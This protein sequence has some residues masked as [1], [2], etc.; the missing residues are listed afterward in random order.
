MRSGVLILR[1]VLLV[2]ALFQVTSALARSDDFIQREIEAQIAESTMLRGT[3]IE[4]HVEQRLVV[5]TVEV[6]LYEQKL[7]ADRIAWTTTGVFEVDNEIRVVPKLPL[8]DADTERK[9]KAIVSADEHF[10]AAGVLV[11]VNNGEVLL[12]GSFLNLRGASQLKHKVAE[13]EGVVDIKISAT[14]LARSSGT[15]GGA[16]V[17]SQRA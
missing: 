5:L 1:P 10:R 9:I 7:I 8:S 14:F 2:L 11:K 4:I 16:G 17:K 13:I 3:Q 15:E 12:E 6:R